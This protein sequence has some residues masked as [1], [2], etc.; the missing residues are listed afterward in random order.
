MNH[1]RE[2]RGGE[3]KTED[4]DFAG[5]G[6]LEQRD[7]PID[8]IRLDVGGDQC[9]LDGALLQDRK[10]ETLAHG[11]VFLLL[12]DF[13]DPLDDDRVVVEEEVFDAFQR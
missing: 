6:F 7:D 8:H 9:F 1:V 3:I 10:A 12:E 2:H 4:V 11:T 5:E 13:D